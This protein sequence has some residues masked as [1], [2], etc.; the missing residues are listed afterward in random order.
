MYDLPYYKVKNQDEIIQF[1]KDHPFVFMTG[2]DAA[3]KPVATQIPVFIDEK[4]GKYFGPPSD[5]E[6]AIHEFERLLERGSNF[7]M[8]AWTSFWWLDYYKAW[9]EYL[10]SNFEC[11]LENKQL[12]L[13]DLRSNKFNNDG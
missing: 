6:S 8:I 10:R 7:I 2:S 13:F 9:H 1:M 5:D 3:N 11:V 12:V 4:D